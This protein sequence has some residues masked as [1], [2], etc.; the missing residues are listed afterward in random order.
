MLGQHP[1]EGAEHLQILLK[2]CFKDPERDVQASTRRRSLE[3]GRETRVVN[4]P[5]ASWGGLVFWLGERERPPLEQS[6]CF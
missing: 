1:G 5:G 2:V 4:E 3:G 6:E